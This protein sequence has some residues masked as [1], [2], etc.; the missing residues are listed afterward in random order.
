MKALGVLLLALFATAASAQQR[1]PAQITTLPTTTPQEFDLLDNTGKWMPFGTGTNGVFTV[2]GAGTDV[3]SFGCAADGTDQTTCI[4][5]ALTN[6]SDCVI[7]PATQNGFYVAGTIT[8]TRCLRGTVFNPT[9]TTTTYDL[10]GSSR[11][12]CNNQAAQPC[13]VVNRVLAGT[14]GQSTQIADIALIGTNAGD[15]SSTPVAN[16]WGFQWQQ[17]SNLTINNLQVSNFDTCAYFGP[18]TISPGTGPLGVRVFNGFFSRCKKH[19][20]VVDGVA[21]VSLFGGRFGNVG[22]YPSADDFIYATKTA[23]TSNAGSGPNTIVVDSVQFNT[24]SVGCP[25]R[26]GGFQSTVGGFGANK[27]SNSHIEIL[28]TGYTGSAPTGMICVDNTVPK[29]PGMQFTNNSIQTDGGSTLHPTFN[30]SPTTV[31]G[32]QMPWTDTFSFVNNRPLTGSPFSLTLGGMIGNAFTPTLIGNYMNSN[33]TFTAGDATATLSLIGNYYGGTV[34]NGQWSNLNLVGNIGGITDNATGT[35]HQSN[36]F[37]AQSWTPALSF[38]GGGSATYASNGT[39]YRTQEGGLTAYFAV[40]LSALASPSGNITITGYP[41]ACAGHPASA[42]LNLPANFTGLSGL[43]YANW[44]NGSA[45]INLL[46]ATATGFSN[47][48]GA[49]LTATTSFSGTVTCAV[50]Q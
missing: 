7:I 20:A 21:E 49:N 47:I 9:S 15:R 17:G 33:N 29:I 41:K 31:G 36:G 1:Q 22:D 48:G 19:Y 11:I 39:W 34:F 37:A 4:N 8:V 13:V 38:S 35:V 12:L 32:G 14:S 50:A 23:T 28:D 16:S 44:V 2:N 5:N 27:V 43:P 24:Q 25:F 46:Q 3:R 26:W 42:L 18:A 10:S 6:A 30:I 45:N 40:T